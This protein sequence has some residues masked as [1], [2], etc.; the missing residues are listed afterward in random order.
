MQ[1]L[2]ETLY[3]SE[4]GE[5]AMNSSNCN[6]LKIG[7]GKTI[8]HNK[9]LGENNVNNHSMRSPSNKKPE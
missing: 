3:V 1:R 2:N 6:T 4:A 9:N 5:N 7:D 8:W